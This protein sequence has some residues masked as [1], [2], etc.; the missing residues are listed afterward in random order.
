LQV[1]ARAKNVHASPQKLRL[2]LEQIRGRGVDD[3]LALLH[4]HPRANAR[5]VAKVVESAAANAENNYGLSRRSLY[6]A[7]AYADKGMAAKRMRPRARGRAG[8]IL[9][10]HSHITVVVDERGG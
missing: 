10:R 8:V 6:V 9:K 3:A 4:Y 2:I 1:K 5:L 7:G